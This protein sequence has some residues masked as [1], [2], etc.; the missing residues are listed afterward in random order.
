MSIPIQVVKLK[1]ENP[2]ETDLV[3]Y[4][5]NDYQVAEFLKGWKLEADAV[6]MGMSVIVQFQELPEVDETETLDQN[7]TE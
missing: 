1:R 2:E 6:G 3:T 7:E 4:C 5:E